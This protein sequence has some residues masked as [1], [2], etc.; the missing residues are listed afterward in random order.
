M[1]NLWPVA[2]LSLLEDVK[3]SYE[4]ET[5]VDYDE[6]DMGHIDGDSIEEEEVEM[7]NEEG[8][9]KIRTLSIDLHSEEK[10]Y[11]L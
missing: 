6:R 8:D 3:D 10:F 2:P 9:K 4:E 5:V 11:T 1:R 7:I